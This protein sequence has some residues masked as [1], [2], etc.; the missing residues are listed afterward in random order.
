M[1]SE[2]QQL[3]IEYLISSSDTFA[4]C[5]SI[6]APEFFAPEHRKAVAFIH[7]Y[8][9]QYNATPSA[10]Q[11]KAETKAD[12]TI[13]VVTRDQIKYCCS[14]IETFCKQKALYK[15]IQDSIEH[16][17]KEDYGTVEKNIK[18]ALLVSLNRK[19]GTDYFLDPAT[20]LEGM[21]IQEPRISTGWTD[22][23][24]ALGGGLARTE[25]ILFSAN[26]GGGKS[27]TLS[28]LGLNFLMQGLNVLY[29]SLE[30][31]EIMIAQRYDMM[32][33]EIPAAPFVLWSENVPEII[34]TLAEFRDYVNPNNKKPIG[35]LMIKRMPVGT[36]ANAIRA[37]LKEYELTQGYVPDLI[38]V[39]YLDL[40]SPNEK[41]S[42]DAIFTKD[43]LAAEQLRDIG[44]DYNCVIATASQQNRGSIDKDTSELNQGDIAGG[45]SKVNTVDVYVSI[46]MTP[47][48]KA[49]GE[50]MMTF[51]KTRSS[52]GV[53][54]TITLTWK[55]SALR[56]LNR[57]KSDEQDFAMMIDKKTQKKGGK[58][59]NSKSLD[60]LLG[61][62]T[63]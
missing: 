14:E 26:S 38:I 39:D 18:D 48:M 6:T 42:A 9:E 46:T 60:E 52:D 56:I 12:Y 8:Y 44:F 59:A 53:G 21:L 17:D 33:T 3:L 11:I 27:I 58:K 7:K 63:G 41:V 1:N 62:I 30:L 49:A 34:A 43:K 24:N 28:N 47:V 23:D 31:P 36:N 20:R 13:R 61:S 55:G 54:K 16:I 45:I 51:L 22:M 32:F 50:I 25:M 5:K 40:M 10:E 2:K 4:L 35:N 37:Y 19:L 29:L 57:E 15:A